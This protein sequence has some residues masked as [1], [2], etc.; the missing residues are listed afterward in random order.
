M[1]LGPGPSKFSCYDYEAHIIWLLRTDWHHRPSFY[2]ELGHCLDWQQF[3]PEIRHR[4][5]WELRIGKRG[6]RW[7]WKDWDPRK[8]FIQPNEEFW[9]DAYAECCMGR[10]PRLRAFLE[11][12]VA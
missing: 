3:T 7:R 9:A 6:R 8:H 12:V 11:E 2:H 1:K 4:I 10:R 5:V